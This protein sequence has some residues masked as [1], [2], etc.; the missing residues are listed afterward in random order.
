MF[1]IL[2]AEDLKEPSIRISLYKKNSLTAY[3]QDYTIIDLK[4]YM[5]NDLVKVED[6]VYSITNDPIRYTSP[7]YLYNN[8]ELNLITENLENNGYKFVFD[9]YDGN[10]KIGTINKYFI[11]KEVW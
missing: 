1:D 4:D 2:Q 6:N 11:V 3:N 7:D 10:K 8:F 5:V 9:L